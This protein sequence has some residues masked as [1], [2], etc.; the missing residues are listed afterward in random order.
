M[1]MSRKSAQGNSQGNAQMPRTKIAH[2]GIIYNVFQTFH[3]TDLDGW[4]GKVAE[5][6][7][8]NGII[9]THGVRRPNGRKD[10]MLDEYANGTTGNLIAIN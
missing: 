4:A 9:A 6:N 5:L 8:Q 3:N 1:N 2:N 7:R 10:F